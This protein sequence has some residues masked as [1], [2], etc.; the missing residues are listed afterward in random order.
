[1]ILVAAALPG[2]SPSQCATRCSP[3][4]RLAN[5]A[6]RRHDEAR[7]INTSNLAAAFHAMS[8]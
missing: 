1:M 8:A 7:A 4:T 2:L 5:R 3:M 6:P